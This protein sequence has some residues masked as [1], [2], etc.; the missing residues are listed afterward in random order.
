MVK[1]SLVIGILACLALF[2]N[3]LVASI[4]L[5]CPEVHEIKTSGC[6]KEPHLNCFWASGRH[7]RGMGGDQITSFRRLEHYNKYFNKRSGYVI[8]CHYFSNGERPFTHILYV[9]SPIGHCKKMDEKTVIC[10]QEPG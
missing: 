2:S 10:D 6:M 7:W 9:K 8:I 5:I 1:L 4:T 3:K